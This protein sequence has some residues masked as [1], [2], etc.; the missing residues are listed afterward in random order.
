MTALRAEALL[1]A[2]VEFRLP[3]ELEARVPPEERGRGRDDVRLLVTHGPFGIAQHLQFHDLPS[4]LRPN[5]V[6][7][8]NASATVASAV[9][10]SSERSGAFTVH[11]STRGPDGWCVVEARRTDVRAGDVATLAGGARLTFASPH[12][13]SRRLWSARVEGAG[14]LIAY[15]YRHGTPIAYPHV[16]RAW[17]IE[18]Y[19]NVYASEAGS[20]EMPSAGRPFTREALER[21]R[22]SGVIV[23]TLI[24]HTGVSSPERD[25]P[26]YAEYFK[27]AGDAAAAIERS[28]SLGGR[29]IAV[30]TTVTR[31]L[32]SA[33]DTRGRVRPSRGWTDLIISADHAM[34]VVDG[35]ITGFHEPRSTH[36]AMLL[37]LAGPAHIEAA[38]AQAVQNG[39]LWH[40]FGDSHLILP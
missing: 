17:P 38:Y 31:A 28:R 33:L 8:L 29:V 39:Y 20:A 9:R 7:V 18:T 15:L 1:G 30:G 26:P 32:E 34:R 22:R 16:D 10:A 21:L 19:Q 40:E 13:G 36:L 12:R 23:T 5:D 37:A 4:L 25:E 2:G 24:L 14:D 3:A 11:F 6:V 35:M 27:I